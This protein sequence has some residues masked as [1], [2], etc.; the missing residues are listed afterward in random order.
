[1]KKRFER[2][3]SLCNSNNTSCPKFLNKK[4][5][6]IRNGKLPHKKKRERN[7]NLDMIWII[8][9][10]HSNKVEEDEKLLAPGIICSI[11]NIF[12]ST[13]IYDF[14]TCNWR[15]FDTS[16]DKTKF[17]HCTMILSTSIKTHPCILHSTKCLIII[18]WSFI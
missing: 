3:T 11:V 6:K 16:N 4:R 8:S 5:R 13:G 14:F 2:I 1:M 15:A 10:D 7:S 18:H 9:Y 17:S 12:H